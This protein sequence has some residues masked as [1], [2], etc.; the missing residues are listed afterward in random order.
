MGKS[1][2]HTNTPTPS[3]DII[4]PVYGQPEFLRQCLETLYGIDAGFPFQVFLVD[5]CGPESEEEALEAVYD[6][7]RVQPGLR[8]L[9]NFQNIGFAESNNRG[10]AAGKAPFVL[11]LNSDTRIVQDGWLGKMVAEFENPSV[12]IVG[13]KILFFSESKNPSRPGGLVQTAGIA[14]NLDNMPFEVFKGWPADDPMVNQRRE[15]RAVTGAC[16]LTRRSLYREIGG[17]DR[18]Y[19]AGNF[20]DVDFCLNAIQR[21]FKVVLQPDAFIEH[22]SGGSGN[23][24]TANRNAAIFKGRWGSLPLWDEWLVMDVSLCQPVGGDH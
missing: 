20:E 5:D 17:L 21:K 22:F 6:Q 24:A 10:F 15:L 16:L 2:K 8:I 12:G 13:P 4:I 18:A 7:F 9:H 14:F 1:N 23:S 11:M 3:V 19:G